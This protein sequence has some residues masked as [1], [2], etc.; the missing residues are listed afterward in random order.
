MTLGAISVLLLGEIS[1]Q[2]ALRAINIDVL[3]F[4]FGAFCV[5]EALNRSGYLAWIGGRIVSRAKIRTSSFYW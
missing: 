2:E 4:L 1:P 3:L 5:G